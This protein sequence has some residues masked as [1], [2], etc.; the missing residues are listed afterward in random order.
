MNYV[1]AK[2]ILPEELLAEIQQYIHGETLYIPKRKHER[3]QW[4]TE[5][6]S[7]RSLDER[8]QRIQNR[9]FGGAAIE[10]LATDY[11]L[12]ED[13]IKKIVYTRK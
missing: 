7:R 2:H 10:K 6:G 8:N 3:I 4:G 13:T 12:S 9:F 1:N 5:T 11:C